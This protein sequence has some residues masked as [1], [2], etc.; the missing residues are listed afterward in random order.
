MEKKKKKRIEL[1]VKNEQTKSPIKKTVEL[2]KS[3][4]K[5][6]KKKFVD[7]NT[8]TIDNVP[9]KISVKKMNKNGSKCE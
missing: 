5:N 3:Q 1:S 4:Q 6:L 8:R 7:F 2:T 9:K